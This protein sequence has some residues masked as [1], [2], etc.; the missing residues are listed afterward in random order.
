MSGQPVVSVITVV[1]NE[2][3]TLEATVKSVLAQSYPH[4]EYVVVDGASTDSTVEILR[5]YEDRI[6][7]LVSEPDR[8][9]AHALNKASALA[10]GDLLLFMNAGDCFSDDHVLARAVELI[11]RDLDVRGSIIYGDAVYAHA[12]GRTLLRTSHEELLDR[13]SICHQSVLIGADVQRANPYDERL[14]V[15]M[16]Y[17]LWLRCLGRYPFVKVPVTLGVF[18]SGG[19]SGADELGAEL[20]IERAVVQMINNRSSR[21]PGAMVQALAGI[22]AVE[23]KRGTRR[24]LGD[25]AF[26]KL[27]RLLRRDTPSVWIPPSRDRDPD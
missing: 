15:Y 13:N 11:P 18:T 20:E 1:R 25:S 17:D 3:A 12:S 4:V 10:T 7:Q 22:V 23:A 8:G 24:A 14:A 27:K 16:D 6:G 19:T 2:A 5:S 21:T 9:I 26:L